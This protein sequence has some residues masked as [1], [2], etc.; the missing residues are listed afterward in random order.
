METSALTATPNGVVIAY[1]DSAP[2]GAVKGVPVVLVHGMG[3]DAR[4]W[5][6][7]ARRLTAAG[8]RVVAVDLRGHGRSAPA[9]SYRFSEFAA[10]VA[11][12][13]DHLGF[14][15]VDLVGHS[16]GGH[17]GSLTAQQYPGLV[18]RLVLEE[19]PIP[20]RENDPVP[21]I[22]S[23]RPTP[24]E[25]WHA[26]TSVARNPRAVFAFDR[27]VIES[28]ISQFRTPDPMW[29]EELPGLKSPTLLL[30]GM[31]PGSMV[32]PRLLTEALPLLPNGAVREIPCGHSIH[33]DRSA[34]FA[35]E[36]LPFLAD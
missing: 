19:A 27:S 13:C 16:L 2:R 17:T 34:E 32:D 10:D 11:G 20:L 29:W 22:P 30:R 4:T 33:R 9:S 14:D 5:D 21:E 26:V 25:L 8:R 12:V 35:A 28:V 1:R 36:V 6:R 24:A 15:A 7:F 23:H 3:S 31:G 18:R